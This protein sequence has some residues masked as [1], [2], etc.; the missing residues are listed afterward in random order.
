M[1][2]T[3]QAVNFVCVQSQ[4]IF[5]FW[6][7]CACNIPIFEA[8]PELSFHSLP[9]MLKLVANFRQSACSF[10]TTF[11][12]LA[13]KTLGNP[14]LDLFSRTSFLI[15]IC[16]FTN[17][18]STQLSNFATP[19]TS[20]LS[21][22]F[23]KTFLGDFAIFVYCLTGE[24]TLQFRLF[25]LYMGGNH[26]FYFRLYMGGNNNFYF[27]LYMGGNH[28]FYCFIHNLLTY[29]H[30]QNNNNK[31][32]K[33]TATSIKERQLLLCKIMKVGNHFCPLSGHDTSTKHKTTE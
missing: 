18:R 15:K 26:N 14:D 25:Q 12:H 5:L 11:I 2:T 31:Q 10:L 9:Q 7:Q 29:S 21:F 33:N 23:T 13:V 28:N 3:E 30:Q 16:H 20:M 8:V 4:A 6:Q 1:I 19:R 24:S 27:R 32:T 17:G 22:V